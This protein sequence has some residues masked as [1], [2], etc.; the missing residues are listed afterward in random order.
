M[1]KRRSHFVFLLTMAA[2]AYFISSIAQKTIA[3]ETTAVTSI[4]GQKITGLREPNGVYSYRGIQYAQAPTG[5]LRFKPAQDFLYKA[6]IEAI[7]FPAACP[8]DQGNPDWYRDVAKGFQ[9]DPSLIPDL[10]SISE[11]CLHL[12]IWTKSHDGKKPVMVWI[13]GGANVNGWSYEP[14]YRGQFLATK[15]VVIIS[16]QYRMGPLGFLPT[17]FGQNKDAFANNYGLSDLNAALRWV[18]KNIHA[19]GGDPENVTLFG[20][21]AGGG[22]IAALMLNPASKGLFHKAIIQSGALGPYPTISQEEAAEKSRQFYH[23]LTLSSLEQARRLDWPQFLDWPRKTGIGYYHYP[24][25]DGQNVLAEPAYQSDIPLLIG[26]N[27]NEMLMYLSQDAEINAKALKNYDPKIRAFAAQ[28]YSE[29]SLQL[30]FITTLESFTC[31]SLRLANALSSERYVYNFSRARKGSEKLL[32]YHGAEIP[33][34]FNTHDSWLP[35]EE[36]DRAL[37]A[38]MV[39]YWVNFAAT[40]NPNGPSVPTW[41]NYDTPDPYIQE[42]DS[43]IRKNTDNFQAICRLFKGM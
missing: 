17:P 3:K 36:E 42:L 7:H 37:T 16:V 38:A 2:L 1:L 27:A 6:P 29:P 24:V 23:K 33:Y 12:N 31:P 39:S 30:D 11:D 4:Q 18:Q 34:V 25:H 10:T 41:P 8:Q 14:N 32:A 20:E 5:T 21:S 9:K 22:N 28:K 26:S 13:H 35:T 19:F 43:P 15:D 40:G